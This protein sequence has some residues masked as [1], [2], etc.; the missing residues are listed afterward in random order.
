MAI[1]LLHA[2]EHIRRRL[3]ECK[4][5]ISSKSIEGQLKD[6]HFMNLKY[7]PEL[8]EL[9]QKVESLYFSLDIHDVEKISESINK[10][11]DS[12]QN[13][14]N[15]ESTNVGIQ[16]AYDVLEKGLSV[17]QRNQIAALEGKH[18][19]WSAFSSYRRAPTLVRKLNELKARPESLELFTELRQLAR[20]NPALNEKDT[21]FFSQYLHLFNLLVHQHEDLS[22]VLE[23]T[24]P[25]PQET[26]IEKLQRATD[27]LEQNLLDSVAILKELRYSFFPLSGGEPLW[28]IDRL[29][30]HF[31]HI[32]K[33]CPEVPVLRLALQRIIAELAL[34]E[35]EKAVNAKDDA[36]TTASLKILKE[37]THIT[38]KQTQFMGDIPKKAKLAAIARVTQTLKNYWKV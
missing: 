26:R 9:Q 33:S 31:I 29:S 30:F 8:V 21:E 1:Q 5:V 6:T 11:W 16:L 18:E 35:L 25:I 15:C 19:A 36:K 22:I 2:A 24:K 10:S 27:L 34:Y 4:L 37:I 17:A 14:A 23:S 32:C 7:R 13:I 3:E 20:D 38:V 12:L 28:I